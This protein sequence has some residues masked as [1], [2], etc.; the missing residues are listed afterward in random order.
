M[1]STNDPAAQLLRRK[2]LPRC[3]LS[4]STQGIGRMHEDLKGFPSLP[5]PFS[6]FRFSD[7]QIFNFLLFYFYHRNKARLPRVQLTTTFR[8]WLC[9][10][11]RRVW[12]DIVDVWMCECVTVDR[13]KSEEN[14]HKADRSRSSQSF[15]PNPMEYQMDKKIFLEGANKE[16][17]ER[18]KIRVFFV[19]LFSFTCS[20]T[21]F[22]SQSHS[23]QI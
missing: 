7:F 17:G 5:F 11:A 6:L 2:W 1:W 4:A 22:P 18:Q 12:H 16:R 23:S 10:T 3:S 15:L 14:W 19:F 20:Q 21:S 13:K 9:K 8:R